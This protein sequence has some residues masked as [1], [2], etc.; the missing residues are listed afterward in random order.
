MGEDTTTFVC[1]RSCGSEL[2]RLFEM[3]R[4]ARPHQPIFITQLRRYVSRFCFWLVG[5][6]GV[7][8]QTVLGCGDTIKATSSPAATINCR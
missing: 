6:G 7:W 5:F 2:R 1:L 3:S 8:S 4:F